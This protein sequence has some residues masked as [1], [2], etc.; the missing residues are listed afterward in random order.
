MSRRTSGLVLS[1]ALLGT[2]CISR[3]EAAPGALVVDYE[4]NAPVVLAGLLEDVRVAGFTP[5]YR[6]FYPQI[7]LHDLQECAVVVLLSGNGPGYPGTG[8][9]PGALAPLASFVRGGGVLL[10]GPTSGNPND[11]A[12]DHERSLFNL[13]LQGIGAPI[14]IGDD[15]ITDDQNAFAAPLYRAP[16]A[17]PV[18]G[19][20]MTQ[21]LGDR[22]VTDRSPSLEVGEGAIALLRSFPTSFPWGDPARRGEL[23]LAAMASAG[24]GKVVVAGRYLLT[25][26]G[27]NGK[28]PA[29]PLMPHPQE[30]A[31]LLA[32][33]RTLFFYLRDSPLF[34]SCEAACEP[35]AGDHLTALSPLRAP[36]EPLPDA[37]PADTQEVQGWERPAVE[38][39]SKLAPSYRW[40]SQEGIRS[41]WAYINR[42]PGEIDLLA[43]RM[44]HSGMNLLWGV[45]FPQLLLS[46]SADEKTRG[47]LI[48][49]WE[50]VAGGLQGSPVR[51]F[52]GME[53]PGRWAPPGQMAKA[54][55]A[56][57]REWD[58]PSPWDL[59][60]WTRAIVDPALLAAQWSRAHPAVAGFVVD[61]EMYGRKPLYFGQGLD[62][63]EIPFR[64]F[65]RARG[66]DGAAAEWRLPAGERFPWLRERGLLKDY[67]AFLERR[68][69][70]MGRAL[71]EKVRSVNPDLI[72]GCYTAGILHRWF[73]RGLW[74]GMSEPGKPV[75]LFTFQR[76]VDVDLAELRASGIDALHVRALLMGMIRRKDYPFLFR[77]ALSRHSGYWLNRLTSL[78]AATG[79][80]PI[81]APPDMALDEAWDVI[82]E[83][84]EQALHPPR[85]R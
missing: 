74:R 36:Q 57:G 18:P 64:A 79:F 20:P 14:R 54:I 4:M 37:P 45:G 11:E 66:K 47:E 23:P 46:P 9:S 10:L 7:T 84:N 24:C 39:D 77:D 32:F 16:F 42:E 72:L 34:S 29:S 17:V 28:E 21:G 71:R 52:M 60:F 51:W 78:V 27:G 6:P 85:R 1:L 25:W 68:A 67:Y 61:L 2:A 75:V 55:G 43:S 76:D 65:L 12:G 31:A 3:V 62:F 44:R 70:E 58:A 33:R 15:W 22:M 50:S 13:L 53:F 80:L 30:E 19:H 26:G 5:A 63:G 35:P 81:E 49:H 59:D 69:E 41:G 38:P 48:G 82:R 73:Y 8:M 83:A 40:I 56:E